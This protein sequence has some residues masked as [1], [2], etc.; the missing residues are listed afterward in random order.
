MSNNLEAPRR[1]RE[2]FERNVQSDHIDSKT[3][4]EIEPI[5]LPLGVFSRFV[6]QEQPRLLAKVREKQLSPEDVAERQR[7]LLTSLD[8]RL[9]DRTINDPDMARFAML[10]LSFAMSAL[11]FSGVTPPAEVQKLN[12]HLAQATGLPE[13]MTFEKIISVNSKLPFDQMRTFTEGA[14]GDSE[15]RFYYGHDLMDVK[16]QDTTVVAAQSIDVLIRQ[17]EEGVEEVVDLLSRG[18]DN[19]GEFAEFMRSFMRMP[20][21]HFGVFRQYLSQYPDG[22]RNASG[23]FIGLPR[24]NIRLVGL[25]PRYEQFLDEGMKY[26]PVKE[27]RD[28][29]YARELAQQGYYLVAQCEQLEGEEQKRV[30]KAVADVIEPIKDFRLRHLAAVNHFVPQALSEGLKN[31]K[32]ELTQTEEEPI[33]EEK[34]GVAKGTAG[35]LAGPLLRNALRMDIRAL[36]K[37]NKIVN[38]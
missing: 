19:M 4:P 11:T 15:R 2:L 34:P 8:P 16:M 12:A 29:Q 13:I 1:P 3:S 14:V 24:L 35:F 33:L 28:I 26:F 18:A 31:L 32:E 7:N 20:R 30:S 22:A 10:D 25:T 6:L 23:G 37:L 17:G 36:E 9:V 27:Q 5:V 21:E 38:K